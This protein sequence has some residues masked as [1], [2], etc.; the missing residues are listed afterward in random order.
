VYT[1]K[2]I[3]EDGIT[4]TDRIVQRGGTGESINPRLDL[5]NHSPTGFCWGY[6]GSG[7]AQLALAILC[8]YLKDDKRA[9]SLYQDFK[10]AIISRLPMDENFTLPDRVIEDFI[11][12]AAIR[13]MKN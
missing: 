13:L 3:N 11:T 2:I 10:D 12:T 8:D 9:L 6:G 1:G 7:P 4:D 5:I